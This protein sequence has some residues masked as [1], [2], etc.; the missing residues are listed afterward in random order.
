MSAIVW[1]K[2]ADRRVWRAAAGNSVLT[3]SKLSSGLWTATVDSDGDSER[4]PEFQT[5]LVAQGWAERTGG[6]R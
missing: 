5:R 1:A 2:T 3:V 6:A 4:S